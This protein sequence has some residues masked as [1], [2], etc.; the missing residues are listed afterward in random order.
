MS[1]GELKSV[2]YRFASG[3]FEPVA[4]AQRSGFNE[5]VHCGAGVVIDADGR[6]V[7]SIGDPELS[8][9]LRSS[10]KAFQAA[11]MVDA[12]LDLPANLLALVCASHSGE[13]FHLEG[14]LTILANAG[15]GAD[16]LGNVAT[17]P[18]GEAAR[19]EVLAAGGLASS[20][21]QNCSGKHAGMLA[22]CV[23]NGWSTDDY[24][25]AGHPLQRMISEWI[26]SHGA[27]VHHVGVDGCGA[28]THVLAIRDGASL[29]RGMAMS[30]S[31]V[32]DA[33]AAYPDLVGGTGRDVTNWMR[34]V[35]GLVAKDG[36][37]GVQALVLTEGERRGWAALYKIADGNS[38]VRSAVI[39]AALAVMGVDVERVMAE[40]GLGVVPVHG[41][42]VPVGTIA[43]IPWI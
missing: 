12:G 14:V 21:F 40:S 8:I 30:S 19:T 27:P 28:P 42:G 36:A 11:A 5:S 33:M 15:L 13:S 2:G 3:S 7:A 32:L 25:D 29:L 37:E 41:G 1:S 43:P 9:Y 26:G 10:L 23:V 35:P 18:Y 6:L 31:S 38:E 4:I 39:P 34:A 22:T 24:L 20:L 16:A 17:L